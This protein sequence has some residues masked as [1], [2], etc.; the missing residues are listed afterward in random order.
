MK[1]LEATINTVQMEIIKK[2]NS[3]K[4]FETE[5]QEMQGHLQTL[6]DGNAQ[7]KLLLM[8]DA[9]NLKKLAALSTQDVLYKER[10]LLNIQRELEQTVNTTKEKEHNIHLLETQLQQQI[11][12][13]QDM[14]GKLTESRLEC[15]QLQELLQQLEEKYLTGGQSTQQHIVQE[16]REEAEKLRQMLKE[17]ELSADEDKYLHNKM[18]EDCGHLIGKNA[19]LRTQMLE[20]TRLLSKVMSLWQGKESEG[21]SQHSLQSQLRDLERRHSSIQ[22]ENSKLQTEKTHLVDYIS[23]LHEQIAEKKREIHGLYSHANSL[24][25]DLGNLKSYVD[26]ASH[27]QEKKGKSA[28]VC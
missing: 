21:Q 8:E 23:Y 3:C 4:I 6:S 19:L 20:A 10:E 15:L 9:M 25:S 27:L 7:E 5:M 2:E 24:S 18:A 1:E 13:L 12:K 28:P 17:R 22:L 14:E 11:Q 16:L 26:T